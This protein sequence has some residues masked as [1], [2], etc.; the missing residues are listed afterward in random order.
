[1]KRIYLAFIALSLL[2]IGTSCTKEMP[3]PIDEVKKGVIIDIVRIAGTEG[4]LAEGIT[5]GNFKVKLTIPEEQGDFSFMKHAQLLAVLQNGNG[6]YTTKVV[7]DNIKEFPIVLQLDMADIYSKLGLSAPALGETLYLTTNVVLEDGSIIPG[8]N[9]L[10]GFN[11]KA[12]GGWIVD[13]RTYSYNV[14]FA[15]ACPLDKDP[16]TGTFI[17]SFTCDESS[18]Y[19][20][21]SYT[22]TVTY[23]PGLPDVIPAGVTAENL[24]GLSI[25]P[26]SPNIW[27]P[28]YTVVNVWIN[29]EDLSLVI[30]DQDTGDKYSNGAAILWYGFKNTGV[31]TCNKTLQFTTKPFIPG[32]G[33]WAEFTFNIHP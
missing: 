20:K 19:G 2:L 13:G 24:Y 6:T 8:W 30:P 28:T 31:S 9:E 21:D 16:V 33:G 12:F 22:V 26:I 1:M 29:T 4:V 14:R 27:D 3:Y 10:M 17:G 23:N 18:S 25:T 32:L 11:N 15:V 7:V 5:D